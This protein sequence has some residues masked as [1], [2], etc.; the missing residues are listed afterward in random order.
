MIFHIGR[1]TE[2]A[3]QCD[4]FAIEPESAFDPGYNP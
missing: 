2:E 1:V 4:L 3:R